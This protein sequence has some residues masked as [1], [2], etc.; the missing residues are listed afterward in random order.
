MGKS[1]IAMSLPR[2]IQ[3]SKRA[4]MDFEDILLYTY[5]TWGKQQILQYQHKL[6]AAFQTISEHPE[7]GHKRDDVPVGCKSFHVG[8]HTII[9][10]LKK[11]TVYIFRILH[12]KMDYKIRSYEE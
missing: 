6:D 10:Q 2:N 12:Q 9:Y 1:Q 3:L 8:S 11:E 4:A 7:I 5:L